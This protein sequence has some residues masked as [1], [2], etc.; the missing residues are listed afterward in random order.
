M[1]TVNFSVPEEVK[2]RF[3]KVFAKTNK[4]HLIAD[5]MLQAVEEHERK[6]KRAHAIDALLK[7]REKQKPVSSRSARAL[8]EKNRE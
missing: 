1:A 5:L 2:A 4:S 3:N 7:L 6:Q 8:R